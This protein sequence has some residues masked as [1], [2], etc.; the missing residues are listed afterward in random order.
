MLKHKGWGLV[1][2]LKFARL[3]L[4]YHQRKDEGKSQVYHCFLQFYNILK[5]VKQTGSPLLFGA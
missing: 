1:G 3:V 5:D 2:N 4:L